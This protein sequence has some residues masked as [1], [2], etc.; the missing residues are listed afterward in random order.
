MEMIELGGTGLRVSRL[1][2]GCSHLASLTTVHPPSEVRAA[3]RAA[4]DAGITFFDTADVYGQGDSERM[5][6]RALGGRGDAVVCTKAGLCLGL[7]QR[8]IRW[9]KPLAAPM[10]RRWRGARRGTL[11]AREAVQRQ[12]FEPAY[13]RRC[14]EG[15]LRRLRRAA[16]DVFL[17]H[18][19]LPGCIDAGGVFGLL[20][21]LR[22]K[23]LIRHYGVSCGRAE[24]AAWALDQPG[25]EVVELPVSVVAPEALAGALPAAA[26]R[27]VG[28]VAR[29]VLGGGAALEDA[30]VITLCAHATGR[31]PAGVALQFAARAVR[32]GVVL[33]RMDS[34]RHV[35]ENL[36][37]W[38]EAPLGE[39]EWRELSG[40]GDGR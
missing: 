26:A 20:A 28:V 5:L 37:A 19:P 23:G 18:N 24:H 25:V 29:E 39:N 32:G 10:L 31:T 36:R 13:L 16:L 8:A 9:I 15:S 11:G 4:L 21:G 38:A 33:V 7:S 35:A 2:L 30:R 14:I 17:L 34:R 12:C 1:G 22:E 3:L 40:A 6:G 27:R